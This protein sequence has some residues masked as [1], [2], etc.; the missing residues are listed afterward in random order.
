MKALDEEIADG[1][2]M[3]ASE[4]EEEDQEQKA[5]LFCSLQLG[6]SL[7][8]FRLFIFPVFSLLVP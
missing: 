7:H 8:P 2:D 3:M 5:G 6:S 1:Q 4:D